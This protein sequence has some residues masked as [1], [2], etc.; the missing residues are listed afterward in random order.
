[1]FTLRSQSKTAGSTLRI[2]YPGAES[3]AIYVDGTLVEMN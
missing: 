1:M 2:A 3:R